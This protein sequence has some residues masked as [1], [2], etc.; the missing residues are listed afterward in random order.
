MQLDKFAITENGAV[1]RFHG[2]GR[3]M[4]LGQVS[5]LVREDTPLGREVRTWWDARL[6]SDGPAENIVFTRIGEFY[7]VRSGEAIAVEEQ[8]QEAAV[9]LIAAD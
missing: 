7:F 9:A 3:P 6:A 2:H 1:Y 5:S 4:L 8:D